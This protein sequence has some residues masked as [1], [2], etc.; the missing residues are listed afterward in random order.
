VLAKNIAGDSLWSSETFGFYVD[1]NA[2]DIEAVAGMQPEKFT[3][4]QNYPNPFNPETRIKYQV[5]RAGH[6]ELNVYN[7]LGQKVKTLVNEE[8]PSGT[9]SVTFDAAD[10]ASGIYYYQLKADGFNA[11]KKMLLVR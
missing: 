4:F 10:L 1:H 11:V 2:T 5:Q 8:K 9:H 3:L 7:A 6:V